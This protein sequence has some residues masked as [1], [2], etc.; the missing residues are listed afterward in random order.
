MTSFLVICVC[1]K[2]IDNFEIYAMTWDDI[3]RVFDNRHK[4]FISKLEFKKSIIEELESKGIVLDNNA[5]DYLVRK[6]INQ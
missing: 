4:N 2:E 1:F 6:V 5:S 3:F